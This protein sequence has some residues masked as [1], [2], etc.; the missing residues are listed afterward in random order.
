MIRALACSWAPS[1]LK[2][3]SGS[4]D[5]SV[6][7]WDFARGVTDHVM[8]GTTTALAQRRH[9]CTLFGYGMQM[10]EYSDRLTI[11]PCLAGVSQAVILETS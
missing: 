5:S 6:K 1:D 2:F 3:C 11:A 8:T 9:C 7:V 4:D 10:V